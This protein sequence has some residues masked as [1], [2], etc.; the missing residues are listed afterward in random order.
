MARLFAQSRSNLASRSGSL[1][2]AAGSTLNSA[3]TTADQAEA[4][5]RDLT[6]VTN[7]IQLPHLWVVSTAVPASRFSMMRLWIYSMEPT[8]KP[9]ASTVLEMLSGDSRTDL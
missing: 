7:L 9:R 1:A 2:N 6:G 4:G 5:A 3:G 8:S